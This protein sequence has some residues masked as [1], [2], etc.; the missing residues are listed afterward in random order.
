MLDTEHVLEQM[1]AANP[2]PSPEQLAVDDL[3][4]VR[5]IV[6]RE[7]S[8]PTLPVGEQPRNTAGPGGLLH[9]EAAGDRDVGQQ[10][11]DWHTGPA[12]QGALLPG[13]GQGLRHLA[14]HRGDPA[15]H[16]F[17]LERELRGTGHAQQDYQCGYRRRLG[18]DI[19]RCRAGT[20][21][22]AAAVPGLTGQPDGHVRDVGQ[23]YAVQEGLCGLLG[24]EPRRHYR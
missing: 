24:S 1:R 22:P 10:P 3:D 7:R 19:E 2:A 4:V 11:G 13:D 5:E 16:L 17:Q 8:A 20:A 6:A 23:P 15:E 12:T 14:E 21:G 9:R 18:P